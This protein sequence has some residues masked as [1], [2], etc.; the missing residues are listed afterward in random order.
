MESLFQSDSD[1]YSALKDLQG[2]F[3]PE[4]MGCFVIKWKKRELPEDRLV[5]VMLVEKV[6]GQQLSKFPTSLLTP[7]QKRGL[8]KQIKEIMVHINRRGVL[9]PTVCSE[10]FIVEGVGKV[11]LV[12]FLAA[13]FVGHLEIQRAYQENAVHELLKRS[14]LLS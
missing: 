8:A 13:Q 6:D 1:V 7:E 3:I 9:M 12:D 4:C 5:N 2:Q 14:G 10:D 11:R